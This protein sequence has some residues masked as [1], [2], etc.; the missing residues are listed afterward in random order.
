MCGDRA[1]NVNA[2][3]PT[4]IKLPVIYII[5]A[6]S[7]L[8]CTLCILSHV[9]HHS[10]LRQKFNKKSESWQNRFKLKK[11]LYWRLLA[12]IMYVCFAAIWS[13][14]FAYLFYIY[15][16]FRR[17]RFISNDWSFGQIVAISV[18][19]PSIV[20]FLYMESGEFIL[21][22]SNVMVTIEYVLTTDDVQ[23]V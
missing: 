4:I 8:C 5:R 1:A 9:L 6:F 2:V 22:G 10:S 3:D 20:E 21:V 14:S 7:V 23:L 13:L 19:V 11:T 16:H 18:W 15:D 12:I 17:R